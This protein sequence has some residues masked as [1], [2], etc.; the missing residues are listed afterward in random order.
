M[1]D[2]SQTRATFEAS[3]AKRFSSSPEHLELIGA[4]CDLYE[5]KDLL[6][7]EGRDRP[8]CELCCNSGQC[9]GSRKRS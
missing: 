4:L 8:L 9:W 3:R 7:R 2:F 5:R 6:D 1:N